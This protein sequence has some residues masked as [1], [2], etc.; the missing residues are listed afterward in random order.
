M[1][2]VGLYRFDNQAIPWLLMVGNTLDRHFH[3]DGIPDKNGSD[4]A[5]PFVS[6]GH[7]YLVDVIGCQA[8]G[9]AEDK[10][11]VSDPFTKRLHLAPFFIHMMRKEVAGLA[12]V[13]HDIRFCNRAPGRLPGMANLEFLE[14]LLHPHKLFI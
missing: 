9:D 2:I 8:D 13:D 4:K 7:R 5:Q 10:C 3:P 12:G 1:L 11:A 14:I 6:I